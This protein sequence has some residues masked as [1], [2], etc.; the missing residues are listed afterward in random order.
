MPEDKDMTTERLK[1]PINGPDAHAQW[2]AEK[3]ERED[4]LAAAMAQG[5]RSEQPKPV[6]VIESSP[7]TSKPEKSVQ[8]PMELPAR[9]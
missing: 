4:Q 5:V 2:E 9:K 1:K 7:R 3:E 6:Q 8:L